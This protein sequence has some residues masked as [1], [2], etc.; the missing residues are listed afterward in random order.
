M[1]NFKQSLL[2]LGVLVLGVAAAFASQGNNEVKF[3]NK[4]GYATVNRPCD[5]EVECSTIESDVCMVWVDGFSHQAY[6]KLNPTDAVCTQILYRL[7]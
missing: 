1:K 2:P 7:D 6:G 5:T 3:A 4:K